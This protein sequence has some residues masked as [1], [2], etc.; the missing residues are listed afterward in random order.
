MR[1][2]QQIFLRETL[3]GFSVNVLFGPLDHRVQI[4][5]GDQVDV[6][7]EVEKLRIK[8]AQGKVG[9]RGSVGDFDLVQ[10]CL[11]I[12]GVEAC[13]DGFRERISDFAFDR[14]H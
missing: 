10:H 11:N 4:Q 6:V 9:L 13:L 8:Q 14:R 3:I 7:V 12:I 1:I 2:I 5:G